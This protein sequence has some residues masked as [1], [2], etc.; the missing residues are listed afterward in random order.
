MISPVSGVFHPLNIGWLSVEPYPITI[1][2]FNPKSPKAFN[3]LRSYDS[4]NDP[5]LSPGQY[6]VLPDL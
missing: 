1:K 5:M 6:F 4:I 2:E 3:R